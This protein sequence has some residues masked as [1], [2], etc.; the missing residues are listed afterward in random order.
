MAISWLLHEK[1]VSSVL[2]G[3]SSPGQLEDNV[4]AIGNIAFS[5]EETDAIEKVL[6]G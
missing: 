3:A 4:R 2:I 5:E 1:R 6:K